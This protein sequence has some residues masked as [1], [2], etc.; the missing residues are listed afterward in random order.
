MADQPQQPLNDD[1]IAKLRSLVLE[2]AKQLGEDDLRALLNQEQSAEKRLSSL[3]GALPR[4]AS[5]VRLS[6]S[7]I[8]DY[9]QG[10][11]RKL[12]WWSVASVAAA[13]GYF[14]A[15]VDLIPDFIPGLGYLDDAAVFALVLSGIREDLKKYAE[16]KGL[17]L[18]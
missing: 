4:L 2:R 13:L 8:K 14:L 1:E 6:F 9:L 3:S 16:A 18:E 5:H 11:Y 10:N 17:R 7:M 15:P 12:P